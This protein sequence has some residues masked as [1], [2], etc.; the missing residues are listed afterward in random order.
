MT[1]L[2]ALY[3]EGFDL[4]L[5]Y[6]KKHHLEIDLSTLDIEEVEIEIVVDRA[7]TTQTNDVVDE[8]AEAPIDDLVGL[9]NPVDPIDPIQPWYFFLICKWALMFWGNVINT[10]FIFG[11]VSFG[12]RTMLQ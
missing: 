3:V 1:S 12:Q 2:C 11:P 4:V 6:V 9:V 8:E 7:A 5:A 10:W